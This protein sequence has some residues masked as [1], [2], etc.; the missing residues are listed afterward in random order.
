MVD[1]HLISLNSIVFVLYCHN[2]PFVFNYFLASFLRDFGVAFAAAA[3]FFG[4]TAVDEAFDDVDFE[5]RGDFVVA[6][7]T[8]ALAVDVA[9]PFGDEISAAVCELLRVLRPGNN[10]DELATA[11][12]LAPAPAAP[13]A[14]FDDGA[15]RNSFTLDQLSPFRSA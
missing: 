13:D 5:P 1:V 8:T 7:T 12:P 4:V 15:L 14:A 3:V 9:L 2:K 6:D 11:A 10:G